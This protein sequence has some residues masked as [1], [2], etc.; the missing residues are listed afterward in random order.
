MIGWKCD[1]YY[2]DT[3]NGSFNYN[4][5]L[6]TKYSPSLFT[7]AD[8]DVYFTAVTEANF[9]MRPTK[10][11]S[12]KAG[13]NNELTIREQLVQ[14]LQQ[15][16]GSDYY[17][18]Y[19]ARYP[20]IDYYAGS[21]RWTDKWLNNWLPSAPKMYPIWN[22]MKPT[23][24]IRG[25]GYYFH[26]MKK[27]LMFS[28]TNTITGYVRDPDTNEW[29]FN[30][31]YGYDFFNYIGDRG[32]DWMWIYLG[33]DY[34][35]GNSWAKFSASWYTHLAIPEYG[36]ELDVGYYPDSYSLLYWLFGPDS[37]GNK[38]SPDIEQGEPI[39]D[40]PHTPG[41]NPYPVNPN[42]PAGGGGT[43][44]DDSDPITD[45]SLPTISAANTGFTRIYNPSLA[46]VQ[47]LARYLWTD[48]SVI[49]TIWNHIKQFFENPMDAIIGFNLVPVP[50][51]NG[52]TKNFALMFIDTGVE[53]TVAANQFV[54]QDC[55]TLKIEEYYGSA[56]DYSPY[57]KISCYL[58]YIGTVNLNTDEVMGRTLDVKYRVDIV[59]GS[60]VAKIFVDGNCLYQYSGHCA[61]TIP[62]SSAD[63]SNY[64]TAAIS[65]GKLAATALSAGTGVAAASIAP[66]PSQQTNQVVTTTQVVDTARNPASGRQITIGTRTI[67]ETREGPTDQSST[68]ASFA[69]LSP[70]NIANTIGQVM[71]S[72]PH[73]EHSGSFSGNS[74][75][76]GVRRPFIIIERPN[77]CMPENYRHYVGLP[78]MMTLKLGDCTGFTKVQQV[79]LTG[80][81]ATNPEQ[82]EI[83]ELLKNGVIF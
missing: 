74:G 62:F 24:T 57:T 22:G 41:E 26:K 29:V 66:D 39:P 82:A 56:L 44:D 14:Y 38:P 23:D 6:G 2:W 64:V 11:I 71:S 46:Q 76:L 40:T 72:K 27:L 25:R 21:D 37:E 16:L 4:D 3:V 45:S 65:V 67:T 47:S 81:T 51:P 70:Q 31:K 60:C 34:E 12:W 7:I 48:E 59:S 68:Q 52:G 13:G 61:I 54:D 20:S 42:E 15:W 75:Y 80:M 50:V 43:F 17:Y 78:S 28:N 35:N 63:F 58:P 8:Q 33:G 73:I 83:L 18:V 55:G 30:F 1:I 32:V 19:G 10:R 5:K 77:L 9:Q 49:Q 36:Y 69:G 79:Q 53:M